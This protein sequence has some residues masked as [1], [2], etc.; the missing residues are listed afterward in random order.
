MQ[1]KQVYDGETWNFEEVRQVLPN[2]ILEQIKKVPIGEDNTLD[3]LIWKA[4]KDGKFSCKN[5]F[6]CVE[7]NW[8]LFHVLIKKYDIRNSPLRDTQED[9]IAHIFF[10][11]RKAQYILK[12]FSHS[13]GRLKLNTN[14]T[15]NVMKRV[16]G[17]VRIAV[18]SLSWHMPRLFT[19][20]LIIWLKHKL[21][22]LELSGLP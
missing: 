10:S 18:E 3:R 5:C 1:L 16:A 2:H 19:S 4:S 6:S 13:V 20:A 15:S 7:T 8:N 21:H 17:I 14:G 9:Y 11:S 22:F 12:Y